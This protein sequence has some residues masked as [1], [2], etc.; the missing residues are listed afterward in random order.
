MKLSIFFR[1]YIDGFRRMT[2]GRTL[3]IIILVKL[4]ILF[5]VLKFFFF[6][7]FLKTSFATDRERSEHVS[8][9]FT[10]RMNN[11]PH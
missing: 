10:K 8:G 4:F 9:E 6:P 7:D 5:A 2:W 11:A 3:W 1:L